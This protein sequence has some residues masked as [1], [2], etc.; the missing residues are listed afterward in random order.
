MRGKATSTAPALSKQSIVIK[1]YDPAWPLLFEAERARFLEAVGRERAAI[2]H[3]GSTAVPAL[4][5]K[6]IVDVMVGMESFAAADRAIARF[7]ALGYTFAPEATRVLPEDRY[8]ERWS[9]GVEVVHVHLT[10]LDR[11]FWQDHLLFRDFL[12]THPEDAAR[13]ERL[14]RALAPQHT[15]GYTYSQA[16]SA[17]ILQALAPFREER[18]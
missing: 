1:D 18:R 15:S 11:S 3:I 10:A 2:E 9:A 8:F 6:P 13:Y 5:A 7:E 17:F 16:K 14:K 4:A 12:R